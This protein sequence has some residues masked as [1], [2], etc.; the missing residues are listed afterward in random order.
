MVKQEGLAEANNKDLDELYT[1]VL[2]K[3]E[4]GKKITQFYREVVEEV[5]NSGA[6]FIPEYGL[7]QGIGMSL[8][9]CPGNQ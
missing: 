6:A 8:E 7:G 1:K 3:M 5:K 2:R 9:E 4:P